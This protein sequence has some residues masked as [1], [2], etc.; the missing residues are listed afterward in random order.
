M[1]IKKDFLTTNNNV[2]RILDIYTNDQIE[3]I[4]DSY[5]YYSTSFK[6]KRIFKS[7]LRIYNLLNE[8]ARIILK[9]NMTSFYYSEDSQNLDEYVLRV[10]YDELEPLY[11]SLSK[12]GKKLNKRL[13]K[14]IHAKIIK[15]DFI[16]YSVLIS[17]NK[18]LRMLLSDKIEDIFYDF[19]SMFVLL[20]KAGMNNKEMIN[21]TLS[22]VA[23]NINNGIYDD[24][25]DSI[26]VEFIKRAHRL[27]ENGYLSK[28]DTN[29]EY[30]IDAI[31]KAF[32]LLGYPNPSAV[33][34]IFEKIDKKRT[35][36]DTPKST[37][38]S[39]KVEFEPVISKADYYEGIKIISNYYD[40]DNCT[41]KRILRM[42][43]IQYVVMIMQSLDFSSGT[44]ESF[45]TKALKK[46]KKLSALDRYLDLSKKI[47]YYKSE[48]DIENLDHTLHELVDEY[49]K[50][51]NKDKDFWLSSINEELEAL[52]NILNRNHNYELGIKK[53]QE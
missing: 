11:D 12:S 37:M 5:Y 29:D 51:S 48:L 32:S 35:N 45:I 39:L 14:H 4:A 22:I 36:D 44:I 53:S 21:A 23:I 24:K 13:I 19:N 17:T 40:L 41:L 16:N 43:E 50:S 10:E 2:L 52:E 8:I 34:N 25:L 6:D 27:I 38:E 28:I 15:R 30:D 18:I 7:F 31:I 33:S 3:K 9:N 42:S 49:I 20:E 1:T 46:H 26:E 47:E